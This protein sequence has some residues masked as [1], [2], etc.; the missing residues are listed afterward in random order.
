MVK[1]ITSAIRQRYNNQYTATN[2]DEAT[3]QSKHDSLQAPNR[4]IGIYK[5]A[6]LD[7]VYFFIPIYYDWSCSIFKNF[8]Q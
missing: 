7:I 5:S 4:R 3:A 2:Y 1:T 8:S 6:F